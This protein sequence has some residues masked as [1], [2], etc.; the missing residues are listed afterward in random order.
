MAFLG[1]VSPP[2]DVVCLDDYTRFTWL[3]LMPHHSQLLSIYRTFSAMIHTQFSA[4]IK[5][6]R[7][8]SGGEYTSYAFRA[9]LSSEVSSPPLSVESPTVSSP[10]PSLPF[11]HPPVRFT[12]HRRDPASL[13]LGRLFPTPLPTIDPAH[14]VPTEKQF[15][16]LS[17]GLPWQRSLKL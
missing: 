5:T 7:S 14:E 2:S 12:Y 16:Y 8:D 10:P 4:S 1:V 3:Y 13:H 9:F 6:F 17:G 11:A 15:D